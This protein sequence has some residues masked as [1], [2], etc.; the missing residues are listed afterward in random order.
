MADSIVVQVFQQAFSDSCKWVSGLDRSRLGSFAGDATHIAITHALFLVRLDKYMNY[1]TA[2]E[3]ADQ[4]RADYDNARGATFLNPDEMENLEAE[5][6]MWWH[7]CGD[8]HMINSTKLFTSSNRITRRVSQLSL[9]YN[10][11]SMVHYFESD[12]W[13]VQFIEKCMEGGLD[14]AIAASMTLV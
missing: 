2:T 13:D 4:M 5:I 11:P 9:V 14:P 6:V 1:L 3:L 7:I 8:S 12:V 10:C